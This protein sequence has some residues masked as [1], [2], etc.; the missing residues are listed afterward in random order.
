MIMLQGQKRESGAVDVAAGVDA[1]TCEGMEHAQVTGMHEAIQDAVQEAVQEHLEV[2]VPACL[3]CPC[4]FAGSHCGWL[5]D[6]WLC[7]CNGNMS[8]PEGWVLSAFANQL[9]QE[10]SGTW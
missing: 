7:A 5:H 3:L 1:D 4:L 8:M 10:E 6:G 9:D 2:S